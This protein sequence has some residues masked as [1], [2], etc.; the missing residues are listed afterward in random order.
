MFLVFG[1]S[2]TKLSVLKK[3]DTFSEYCWQYGTPL[4][5]GRKRLKDNQHD[6]APAL[7]G[8]KSI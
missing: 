8:I 3:S 2:P 1:T 6:K 5:E 4:H 7:R